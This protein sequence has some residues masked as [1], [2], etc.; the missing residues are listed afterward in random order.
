MKL[1]NRQAALPEPT[2]MNEDIFNDI[3]EQGEQSGGWSDLFRLEVND[4]LDKFKQF[5]LQNSEVNSMDQN[6]IGVIEEIKPEIDSAVTIDKMEDVFM[7]A[8]NKAIQNGSQYANKLVEVLNNLRQRVHRIYSNDDHNLLNKP[9]VISMVKEAFD[10]G[11]FPDFQTFPIGNTGPQDVS[12]ESQTTDDKTMKKNEEPPKVENVSTDPLSDLSGI[13]DKIHT[14]AYQAQ[15]SLNDARRHAFSSGTSNTEL[16][17]SLI[18]QVDKLNR[19]FERVMDMTA[20][21]H[22]TI[23]MLK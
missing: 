23:R 21:I 3:P 5:I 19:E 2:E 16:G 22:R 15:E 9:Q 12:M 10:L 17:V 8:T 13:M 20:N 18:R 6:L 11:P 7:D 14:T 4:N 1:S